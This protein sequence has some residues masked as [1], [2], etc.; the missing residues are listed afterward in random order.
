[1]RSLNTNHKL[2]IKTAD[3]YPAVINYQVF[4]RQMAQ[5]QNI[6]LKDFRSIHEL[7]SSATK[8]IV[9]YLNIG[10]ILTMHYMNEWFM[11]AL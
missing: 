6:F 3:F 5:L 2:H 10:H 9:L 8:H 1:M 11:K 7:D 4:P